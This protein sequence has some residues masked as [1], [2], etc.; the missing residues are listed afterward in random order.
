MKTLL[1]TF[2]CFII[3]F[4]VGCTSGNNSSV[5]PG[6]DSNNQVIATPEG[7]VALSFAAKASF[8]ADITGDDLSATITI[9]RDDGEILYDS[10]SMTFDSGSFL[11]AS[12]IFLE[13]GIT[14]DITILV[15]D[16]NE[17]LTFTESSVVITSEPGVDSQSLTIEIFIGTEDNTCL[18]ATQL[19]SIVPVYEDVAVNQKDV[20]VTLFD[21]NG[22]QIDLTEYLIEMTYFVNDIETATQ[23]LPMLGESNNIAQS[24]EITEE[25]SNNYRHDFILSS[26]DGCSNLSFSVDENFAPVVAVEID[27]VATIY[28]ISIENLMLN[29]DHN[30][31]TSTM[32][33]DIMVNDDQGN[34]LDSNLFDSFEIS[35]TGQIL[36]RDNS[37][38]DF[39]SIEYIN[40]SDDIEIVYSITENSVLIN[41]VAS[42]LIASVSVIIEAIA[43]P[44]SGYAATVLTTQSVIFSNDPLNMV[45]NVE[46]CMSEEDYDNDGYTGSVISF[47]SIEGIDHYVITTQ[48]NHFEYTYFYDINNG[49]ATRPLGYS[50]DGNNLE[51]YGDPLFWSPHQDTFYSCNIDNGEVDCVFENVAFESSHEEELYIRIAGYDSQNAEYT[52]FTAYEAFVPVQL[53]LCQAN[54][55]EPNAHNDADGD[56]I[57]DAFDNCPNNFNPLQ[58]DDDNNGVGN[59]CQGQGWGGGQK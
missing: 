3:V 36:F 1:S 15:S 18:G 11:P 35:M 25:G 17:T 9:T 31:N 57:I 5:N 58:L 16:G 53:A 32:D 13:K 44:I 42:D 54:E 47:V 33:F 59:V 50:V 56:G 49:D 7:M 38:V 6:N 45:E 10:M 37:Q 55:P 23:D 22:A 14:V 4:T 21:N 51:T 43:N 34:L 27:G 52:E 19:V 20:S 28:S 12:E 39:D 24:F 48:I 26:N 40:Q 46:F 29:T 2:L 8:A 30:T 41:L